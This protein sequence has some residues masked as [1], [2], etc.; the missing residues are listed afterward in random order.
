MVY[1]L[2]VCCL[3]SENSSHD[4]LGCQ[5]F[6]VHGG[7]C[8]VGIVSAAMVTTVKEVKLCLLGVSILC[9]V[10]VYVVL[11]KLCGKKKFIHSFGWWRWLSGRTSVFGRRTFPVLRPTCS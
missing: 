6:Q 9:S 5:L 8:R 2:S 4:T 1:D 10:Y 7:R 11:L 3:L